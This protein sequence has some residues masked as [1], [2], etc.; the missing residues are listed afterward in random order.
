MGLAIV[1]GGRP[2]VVS[3]TSAEARTSVSAEQPAPN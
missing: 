3:T 2:G 1:S